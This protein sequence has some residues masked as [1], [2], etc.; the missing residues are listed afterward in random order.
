ML[1]TSLIGAG[2]VMVAAIPLW[3]TLPGLSYLVEIIAAMAILALVIGQKWTAIP[4]AA[5]VALA[6]GFMIFPD[7]LPGPLFI[8]LWVKVVF[9][10]MILGFLIAHGARA[11]KAF[12]LAGA[13]T[14]GVMIYLYSQGAIILNQQMDQFGL[15]IGKMLTDPMAAQGHGAE[16]IADV[17]D[18]VVYTMTL[19]KRILPGILAVSGLA[20]LFIAFVLIEWYFTR[21]DSFFPG[22]GPFLFW[23]IPEPFLYLTGA[24]LVTRLLAS[25]FW[26][27]AADNILFVLALI[28]AIGGLAMVEHALRRLRLPLLVK[29]IFYIGLLLMQVP[30]L[31][32]TAVVGLFDSYFDFRRVRAHTLG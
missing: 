9:P 21:R 12:V 14:A 23:K 17:Q 30:G 11:G 22:F 28:Y 5:L 26:Q 31:I 13:V 7:L 20:Q 6:L 8:A 16:T 3:I 4:P 2:L 1:R 27:I 29:I 18:K 25:G 15:T 32:M 19:V 24:T 10:P